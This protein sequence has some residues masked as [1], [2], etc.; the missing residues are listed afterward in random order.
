MLDPFINASFLINGLASL[1]IVPS[2]FVFWYCKRDSLP[3]SWVLW[4]YMAAFGIAGSLS[5]VSVFD[6]ALVDSLIWISALIRLLIAIFT[7][8]AVYTI[9]RWPGPK[10]LHRTCKEMATTIGRLSERRG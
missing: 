2:I 1:A 5:I 4:L 3:W 9:T 8:F 10:E 6:R 7:P